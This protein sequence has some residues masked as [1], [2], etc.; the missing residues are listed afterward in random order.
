MLTPSLV[1]LYEVP[2]ALPRELRGAGA[3]IGIY[4]VRECHLHTDSVTFVKNDDIPGEEPCRV[5]C[6]E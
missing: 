1:C 6:E 4:T 3:F 5:P 2:G